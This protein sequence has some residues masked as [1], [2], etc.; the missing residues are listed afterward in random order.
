MTQK[1]VQ[2]QQYA[3][4]FPGQG[5]Q[6]VGMLADLYA[7]YPEV[8]EHFELASSLLGYDLWALSQ[9]G[10][11]DALARTQVTQPL[12]LTA[13]IAVWTVWAQQMP[14]R[15]C[16]LAGHSLGEYSALV[17]SGALSFEE[18]LRSVVVRAK[19]METAVPEGEGA[20]LAVLGLSND[21]LTTLCADVSAETGAL[22]ACV[23]MNAPGQTVVG[24]HKKAVDELASRA[25]EAGA[26]RTI[27]VAMSVPSHCQLMKPAA[28]QLAIHLQS[29]DVDLPDVDVLNNAFLSVERDA[30][31]IKHALVEQVYRPVNWVGLIE[32]LISKGVTHIVECGPGKVLTGMNK[33]IDRGLTLLPVFDVESMKKAQVC[34]AP[35][36]EQP[37]MEMEE[38]GSQP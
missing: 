33:R 25:K 27:P 6:S 24:G 10:P 29:I 3:V 7:A 28:D 18:A 19:A 8:R 12:M 15:P 31:A 32:G 35:L 16:A 13:G 26:K 11:A 22:A 34:L 1:S 38:K 14:V 37:L 23:N 4:V 21:V 17:A 36:A 30:S 20:M 5:S 2:S 9:G